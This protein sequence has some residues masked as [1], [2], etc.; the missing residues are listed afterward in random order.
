MPRAHLRP[1]PVPQR[2][3]QTIEAAQMP[4]CQHQELPANRPRSNSKP[5]PRASPLAPTPVP[6]K[7]RKLHPADVPQRRPHPLL[8]LVFAATMAVKLAFLLSNPSQSSKVLIQTR[9][10]RSLRLRSR[11]SS[12]IS[13]IFPS[14]MKAPDPLLFMM[15][16]SPLHLPPIGNTSLVSSRTATAST[17]MATS[18]TT[19]LLISCPHTSATR[20][21]I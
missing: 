14:A 7:R 9:G 12:P 5:W 11:S 4:T 8:I 13:T 1:K 15:T 10:W 18:A 19:P 17:A 16:V 6:G 20:P 3:P 21:P 2:Q